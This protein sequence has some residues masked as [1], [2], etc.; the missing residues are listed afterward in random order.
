V[1]V[2]TSMVDVVA[3]PFVKLAVLIRTYCM[4]NTIPL[5]Q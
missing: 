3:V 2:N 5:K 1:G 4:T